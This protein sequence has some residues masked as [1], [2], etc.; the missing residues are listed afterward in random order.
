M[1]LPSG[2]EVN[3]NTPV[4]PGSN[5]TWG[6]V[7]KKGTRQIEDL[8]IDGRLIIS[9]IAIEKNV[10][11]IAQRMDKYRGMLG[12]KPIII[13]SWYRPKRVNRQVSASKWSLHQYG[14]AVDWM[15]RHM[16]S[17]QIEGILE[18]QHNDGGYHCYVDKNFTHTDLRGKK[19]RW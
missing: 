8:R 16:T 11:K 5:F 7:T 4:Y 17:K 6:E 1:R 3:N 15:C 2:K 18:P 13:T 10:I 14:N 9:A 19:A 12:N